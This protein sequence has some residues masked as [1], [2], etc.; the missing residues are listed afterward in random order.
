[1]STEAF[2]ESDPSKPYKRGFS[3]QGVSPLPITFAEHGAAHI[4]NML[5]DGALDPAGGKF[6]PDQG[7]PGLGLE[8]QA[9]DAS[10]TGCA[11][12]PPS[13]DQHHVLSAAGQ[14]P[15]SRHG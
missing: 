1:M 3:I 4:E 11:D 7:R 13:G 8:P 5:F 6:R 2:Y 9:A 10:S 14:S 15:G 12:A